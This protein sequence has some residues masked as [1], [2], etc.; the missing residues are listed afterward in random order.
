MRQLS[1]SWTWYF[2]FLQPV[3]WPVFATLAMLSDP[4]LRTWSFSV[5]PVLGAGYFWWLAYT[6]KEVSLDGTSLVITDY[7][8]T[9]R[10]SLQDV[11]RVW[12]KSRW[13]RGI[14]VHIGLRTASRF[15]SDILFMPK[16]G[17]GYGQHPLIQE[18]T[19]KIREAKGL[20]P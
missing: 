18:L 4:S 1:T 14:T 11:E 8:R 20:E 10:V 3:L 2:K 5:L 6:I 12:Q 16:L 13:Q 9:V 17:M 7:G 19:D 15:G